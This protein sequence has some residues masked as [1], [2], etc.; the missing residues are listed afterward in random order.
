M[1]IRDRVKVSEGRRQVVTEARRKELEKEAVLRKET[2]ESKETTEIIGTTETVIT[3]KDDLK[4]V[5]GIGP[6]IEELLNNAGIY[7]FSQLAAKSAT[8]IKEILAAAG[9]RYRIHDPST[10]GLQSELAAAGKWD[11]LRS[12]QDEL[13]GGKI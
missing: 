2:R 3:T 4:V 10:W 6:K 12:W 9:K 1:C 11:E 8:E 13:Q 7:T 5:E